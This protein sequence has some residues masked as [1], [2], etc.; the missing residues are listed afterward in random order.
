MKILNPKNTI[1]Y[2]SNGK[3]IKKKNENTILLRCSR[4]ARA[5]LTAL[6]SGLLILLLSKNNRINKVKEI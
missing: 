4:A 1:G 6:R 5:P 3:S 2:I